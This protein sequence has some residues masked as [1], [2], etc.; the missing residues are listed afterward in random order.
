MD[1]PAFRQ[2]NNNNLKKNRKT[3]NTIRKTIITLSVACT[4]ISVYAQQIDSLKNERVSI[5]SQMTIIH[6]YKPAFHV[7]YTGMNSLLPQE[8]SST[9]ITSTLYF[10]LRLWQGGSLVIDPE[11]AG[12]SGLSKTLG[13]AD[14]PNGETFRIADSAPRISIARL[15]YRQ[16]IALT[17]K[18]TYQPSDFNKLSG[19]IP[20]KYLAFTVGGISM[21]DYFDDNKY[22]HDP[23]TQFMTWSL[24]DAGAWDYPAN[25]RGYTPSVVIEY[26][27]PKNE[28][29]YGF[30]LMPKVANGNDMNWNIAKASSQTLE[31]THHYKINGLDGAFRI[32]GF[33][34]TA[35]MGNYLQSI[36]LNPTAPNIESTRK[37]GNTKYGVIINAEQTLTNDL[38]CFLRGS[39]NDGNNETWVFTEID[40]SI[41]AGLSLTGASWKR[42]GDN[43]GLAYVTSG[44]SKTHRKYLAD[45]GYG[46][47]LGDGKLN[48]GW[49]HVTELYYS[50]EL[51]KNDIYLTG[52][53]QFLLN[54]GYNRDRKGPVNIFSVRLHVRI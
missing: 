12:G 9:S 4:G 50:A 51:V 18:T 14:A 24:M 37:Y 30:A 54:P 52:A 10:G 45:G 15:F 34:N 2:K 28:L 20:D 38:G 36:T 29:R 23:R 16:V 11:L 43:I 17:N 33:F 21:T 40:H 39:W 49:E 8:E 19:Y 26:V 22:S 42:N 3:M 47:M 46:F 48:Y 53:Y 25:T 32:L 41:S 13:V 6:Q 35:N 7:K 5:H 27:S 1:Y 44:I 31:Y